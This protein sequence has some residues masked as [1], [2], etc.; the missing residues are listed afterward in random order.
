MRYHDLNIVKRR[1]LGILLALLTVSLFLPTVSSPSGAYA[2]SLPGSHQ[3]TIRAIE[4]K[5]SGQAGTDVEKAEYLSGEP[6]NFKIDF[7]ASFDAFPQ[8]GFR[9]RL[10]IPKSEHQE[11]VPQVG[12]SS[13]ETR[14]VSDFTSD[15]ANYIVDFYYENPQAINVTTLVGMKYKNDTTPDGTSLMPTL[16]LTNAS[17]ETQYLSDQTEVTIRSTKSFTV[18]KEAYL[19]TNPSYPEYSDVRTS[20]PSGEEVIKRLSYTSA[21]NQHGTV[22]APSQVQYRLG[23]KF[24]FDKV[25]NPH[26]YGRFTPKKIRL[27]DHVPAGAVVDERFGWTK[28]PGSLNSYYFDI[29]NMTS[30]ANSSELIGDGNHKEIWVD[31]AGL[32]AGKIEDSDVTYPKYTNRVEAFEV[33][34]TP[35]QPVQYVKIGEDEETHVFYTKLFESQGSIWVQ[36]KKD[37]DNSS[38][39]FFIGEKLYRQNA[40][41]GQSMP[42]LVDLQ[43]PDSGYEWL[44]KATKYGTGSYENLPGYFREVTDRLPEGMRVSGVKIG[45]DKG[46]SESVKQRIREAISTAGVRVY[47]GVRLASGDIEYTLIADDLQAESIVPINDPMGRYDHVKVEAVRPIGIGNYESLIVSVYTHLKDEQIKTIS[48]AK[49]QAELNKLPG[50]TQTNNAELKY[51]TFD[52]GIVLRAEDPAEA[53]IQKHFLEEDTILSAT[54]SSLVYQNCEARGVSKPFTPAS[55]SRVGT[56]R[57]YVDLM[58][59]NNIL[60]KTPDMQL[61]NPRTVTLLPRGFDFIEYVRNSASHTSFPGGFDVNQLRTEIIHDYKGS[62]RTAVITYFPDIKLDA[63]DF[64][65][66]YGK[67]VFEMNLDATIASAAGQNEVEVYTV[68]DNMD[69]ISPKYLEY[70]LALPRENAVDIYDVDNDG[71]DTEIIQIDKELFTVTHPRGVVARKFVATTE[72][73]IDGSSIPENRWLVHSSGIDADSNMTLHYKLQVVN[74]LDVSNSSFSVIDVLPHENDHNIVPINGGEYL[75][76]SW[77]GQRSD[78]VF[79]SGNHSAFET[80]LKKGVGKI[81]QSVGGTKVDVT[82]QYDVFYTYAEQQTTLQAQKNVLWLPADQV[83]SVEQLQ[84]VKAFKVV[85]KDGFSIPANATLEIFTE[86]SIKLPVDKA[87]AV[88]GSRSVNTFAMSI[89]GENSFQETNPVT[90]EFVKYKVRGIAFEDKVKDGLFDDA[91]D[92]RID[93]ITAVLIHAETGQ[94]VTQDGVP[95]QAQ[96]SKNGEF[97]YSFD[98]YKRGKYRV[99]FLKPN[100]QQIFTILPKLSFSPYANHVAVCSA[101]NNFDAASDTAQNCAETNAE[102]VLSGWTEEFVLDPAH[103]LQERNVGVLPSL[104]KTFQVAW[105]KTDTQS[106]LLG[107]SEWKITG[108]NNGTVT[109]IK[110]TDCVSDPCGDLLDKNPTPGKFLVENLPAGAYELTETVAPLG[111]VKS[112]QPFNRTIETTQSPSAPADWG[113]IENQLQTVPQIPLTGGLGEDIFLIIGAL[114]IL[115]GLLGVTYNARKTQ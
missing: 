50:S 85:L 111:Y 66:R 96:I 36:F 77:S 106:R 69:S 78:G 7:K 14:I 33:V 109:D 108:N 13:H 22:I 31:Y 35:G 43:Q 92:T 30:Y 65:R 20:L 26:G 52:P 84:S 29:E 89:D 64:G 47:G 23:L 101:D 105:D 24:N 60:I 107:G 73:E 46:A 55:C 54:V 81:I 34:E 86:S 4:Y 74:G 41:T 67:L 5:E 59:M 10:V 44:L 61:Q 98:V 19:K 53:R 87:N 114:T 72:S 49:S 17:G 1:Y 110:V 45:P 79:I 25:T 3:I 42:V 18:V 80:P 115:A 90:S 6:F 104:A 37:L 12:D 76:R 21:P 99:G 97:G 39:V 8:D 71:D 11:G 103:R 57:I 68:W 88:D 28:V 63:E 58:E 112:N 38:R 56:L 62:G 100:K 48:K 40:I 70:G 9:L 83:S 94:I 2:D 91:E 95:V 27:V 93:G 82:S 102:N 51:T 75:P 16:S 113:H 15:P 32:P